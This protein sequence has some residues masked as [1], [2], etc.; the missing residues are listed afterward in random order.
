MAIV[1]S[2]FFQYVQ[3]YEAN[4]WLKEEGTGDSWYTEV[5]KLEMCGD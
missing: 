5:T 4:I 2:F 3:V 1:S